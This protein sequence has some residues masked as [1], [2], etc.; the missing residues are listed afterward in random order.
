VLGK[1][2]PWAGL[3]GGLGDGGPAV[4]VLR[5]GWGGEAARQHCWPREAGQAVRP[6]AAGGTR[7]TGVRDGEGGGD[8]N[9]AKKVVS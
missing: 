8:Q 3:D 5:A 9:R 6:T 1:K 7:S 2:G 4:V